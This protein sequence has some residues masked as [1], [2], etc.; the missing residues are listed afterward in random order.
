MC[1]LTAFL[2]Y[3]KFPAKIFLGDTGSLGI[4]ALLAS[5]A[6]VIRN[7]WVL[8]CLGGVFVIE[9][10]SVIIQVA[11][12][13]RTKKRVFLMAPLHHH[14]ELC[15]FSEFR[16]VLLFWGVSLSFFGIFVSQYLK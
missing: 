15:G 16:T 5:M 1:A 12:Y 4:G 14:F 11:Y 6:V 9:T 10:V 2:F 7:P 3:N 8:L 13:K